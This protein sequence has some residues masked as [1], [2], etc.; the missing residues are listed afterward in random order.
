MKRRLKLFQPVVAARELTEPDLSGAWGRGQRAV[1]NG[2]PGVLKGT[3]GAV[4]EI[5]EKTGSL[6]VEFFDDAGETIDVAFLPQEYM[7][8]LMDVQKSRRNKA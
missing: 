8:P 7:Q 2:K 1:I 6:A 3:S 5:F 4:V